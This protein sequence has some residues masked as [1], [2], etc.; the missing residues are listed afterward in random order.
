MSCPMG[1]YS[2]SA[3]SRAFEGDK[4]GLLSWKGPAGCVDCTH[5]VH[6]ACDGSLLCPAAGGQDAFLCWWQ[7]PCAAGYH[8]TARPVRPRV[9]SLKGYRCDAEGLCFYRCP[10][11]DACPGGPSS[12]EIRAKMTGE[13]V[14]EE[15]KC[16]G[17][18]RDCVAQRRLLAMSSQQDAT[19]VLQAS[20][21]RTW[22]LSCMPSSKRL[23]SGLHSQGL[24]LSRLSMG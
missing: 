17:L 2:M 21:G 11:K 18:L 9:Y 8:G 20:D 15:P 3:V 14:S 19:D 22:L 1:Q 23:M 24:R 10:N 7:C 16:V 4:S 12:S 6:K 5:V 13:M